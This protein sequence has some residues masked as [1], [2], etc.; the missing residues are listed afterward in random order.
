MGWI[1]LSSPQ[2]SIRMM[3]ENPG[4]NV[5]SP[6]W[7]TV[8]SS[9]HL[10]DC[11]Q[12]SVVSYAHAHGKKV[13]VMLDNQFSASLTHF[14]V[15]NPTRRQQLVDEIVA[16]CK[17]DKVDGVNID[18]E[19]VLSSDEANFTAFVSSLHQ[20]LQP[21]HDKVSVDITTDIVFLADDAAYFHAGLAA[22]SDYVVLMAY[23]EHWAGDPTPGPV[24]DVPWVT[25]GVND[26]LDTGVPADKI[27]LGLPLY[28]RFWHVY[29]NGSVSSEAIPDSNVGAILAKYHATT[30]WNNALGVAYAKY[31]KSDGYEEAW[32]ETI[33]TLNRKLALVQNDDLAGISVWS[34]NLSSAQTW[35]NVMQA[36]RQS[37]S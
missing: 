28:A 9:G 13:W 16:A 30:S 27:I 34:L 24:A 20:A 1:Q 19:N 15:S 23:D 7:Y 12:P 2:A 8:S 3:Q 14:V 29:N 26:L 36:L 37:L 18:F 4:I 31:K 21:L 33:D 35:S 22:A 10:L 11:A 6:G 25:Q 32:Y 5:I 17:R